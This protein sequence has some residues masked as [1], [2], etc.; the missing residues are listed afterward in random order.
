MFNVVGQA[1]SS[2]TIAFQQ[3][4]SYYLVGLQL[5]YNPWRSING[6]HHS[7]NTQGSHPPPLQLNIQLHPEEHAG[8]PP[9]THFLHWRANSGYRRPD[10]VRKYVFLINDQFPGPTVEVRSGDTVTI[11]V[12]NELED[13]GL[14]IHWHG[15]HMRN[16]NLMDGVAGVTQCDILPA[17]SFVYNFTI[18]A[19]QSGTFWYH[20]HSSTQ[21]ADG[22]YGGFVVH[23]PFSRPTSRSA[24]SSDA[25]ASEAFKHGYEKDVLLLIGDWY[26]RQARDVL[27]WYMRAGSFGNE[28]V[29]DSLVINGIGHFDCSNAV[30]ARPVDCIDS[31]NFSHRP[32]LYLDPRIAYRVRVINTGSL[33]G[34]TLRFAR[35]TLQLIHLDGGIPV[36]LQ[37]DQNDVASAGILFPGQR[38][39]F[40]L[41]RREIHSMQHSKDPSSSLTVELDRSYPNPAL[42]PRQIFPIIITANVDNRRKAPETTTNTTNNKNKYRQVDIDI[43]RVPSASSVLALLPAKAH[44]THVV[45]TKIEKLSRNHNVPYGFIN[46]T[47]WRPQRDPPR[48][49]IGLPR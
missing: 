48:P 42:T 49:L 11:S 16:A 12:D 2:A 38:M 31:S 17:A 25:A 45:Y 40:V 33:A 35:E 29:P 47:C 15:L 19:D 3:E 43:S 34:F 4:W 27:S 26:H 5:L 32:Y 37:P 24:G 44:E 8:R 6:G 41:R 39:D 10:G 1:M 7:N 36:E 22:L 30:P 14:S 28:P 20:A 13:E 9:T 18:S 46:R 21:R 23:K